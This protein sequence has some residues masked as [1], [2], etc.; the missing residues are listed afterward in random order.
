MLPIPLADSFLSPI[1]RQQRCE[2]DVRYYLHH[3]TRFRDDD[4]ARRITLSLANN[5]TGARAREAGIEGS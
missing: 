5:G 3:V 4:V 2:L 1:G